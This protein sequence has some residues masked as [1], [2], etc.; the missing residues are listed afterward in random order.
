LQAK[1]I[2]TDGSLQTHSFFDIYYK[3]GDWDWVKFTAGVGGVYTITTSNLV[4]DTDTV[5]TLYAGPPDSL[6]ELATNDDYPGGGL[7]S[8]IVWRAPE[9]GEYYARVREYL[10]RGGCTFFY[11]LS[12]QAHLDRYLPLV[13]HVYPL[14]TPTPTLTPTYTPTWTPSPTPTETP[15]PTPYICAPIW[16]ADVPLGDHP[17]GVAASDDRIFVGLYEMHALA[18]VDAASNTL[19]HMQPGAGLGAN[20]VAVSGNYVYQAHRDSATMTVFERGG[21]NAYVSTLYVGAL[22]FGVAGN[23]DRVYVANF[24]SDTVTVIDSTTNTVIAEVAVGS[25]PALVA[26]A[27]DRAFVS[28][29]GASLG[30]QVQAIGR[31]GELL[32]VIPT[33]SG[34]FGLAYEP[35]TDRLYVSHWSDRSI[36]VFQA[37]TGALL[38]MAQAPGRPYAL[39]VNPNSGH[40]FVVGAANDQLWVYGADDLILRA[41]LPLPAQDAVDGGQGIAVE[42]N[43]VYVSNYAADSLSVF[44]DSTCLGGVT[45]TSTPTDT[46]TLTPTPTE[47]PTDTPTPT[48][49]PSLTTTPTVTPSPTATETATPSPTSTPTASPTATPSPTTTLTATASPTAT[50]TATPSPTSTLT[51]TSSPTVTPTATSSPTVTPTATPSPTLTATSTETPTPTA[52]STSKMPP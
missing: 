41:V 16:I 9:Y 46:P 18:V 35:A 43:R 26:A 48:T 24:G 51:P 21:D 12:I 15:T 33:A 22:P 10:E 13:M 30:G 31:N 23:G 19:L 2:L 38:R 25:Q 20:G 1:P 50:E 44:D 7:A 36:R 3:D 47:L 14:P 5:L 28:I 29:M 45:P 8:R 32:Y 49:T 11:D 17:K 6:V 52:T 34:P 40:L 37:S 4:S 42:N 27:P 39:A